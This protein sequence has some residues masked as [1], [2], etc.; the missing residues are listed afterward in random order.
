MLTNKEIMTRIL[1]QKEDKSTNTTR[2]QHESSQGGPQI[3]HILKETCD[4]DISCNGHFRLICEYDT[5]LDKLA[6]LPER[7]YTSAQCS[8]PKCSGLKINAASKEYIYTYRQTY[9]PG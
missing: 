6:F 4:Y 7:R 9:I 8:Q 2:I 5:M 3:I 1:K